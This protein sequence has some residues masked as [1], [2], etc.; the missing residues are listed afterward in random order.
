MKV[1]EGKN[2]Y[3][4]WAGKKH[5]ISHFR[6]FDCDYYTFVI[7]EK[8]KKMDMIC[9]ICI[10]M[11][12]NSQQKGYKIYS[13]SSKVVFVSID[14]KFNELLEEFVEDLD[15]FDDSYIAPNWMDISVDMSHQVKN[16]LTQRITRSMTLK[17]FLFTKIDRKNEPSSFK[18]ASK[19]E[20]WME[21][22]KVKYE[23][24]MKNQT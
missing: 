21:V 7:L 14:V 19:H 2:P 10:S 6:I 3:E 12:Y 23:T 5:N 18:E 17:K 11:G 20:Y 8:R 4:A 22:I 16:S 1:I 15:D 24:L 13:L 9:E